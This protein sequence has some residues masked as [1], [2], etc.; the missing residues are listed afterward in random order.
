MKHIIETKLSD[1]SL[2][3]E[4]LIKGIGNATFILKTVGRG[5]YGHGKIASIFSINKDTA[6]KQLFKNVGFLRNSLD[7]TVSTNSLESSCLTLE[8]ITYDEALKLAKDY[9]IK[10]FG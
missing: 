8:L 3:E 4:T 1:I 10:I 7:G 6:E 5:Q 2:A 9:L